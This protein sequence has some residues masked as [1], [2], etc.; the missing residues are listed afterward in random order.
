MLNSD[1]LRCKDEDQVVDLV[2]DYV[3]KMMGSDTTELISKLLPAI[4]D[5]YVSTQKLI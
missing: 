5:E 4:R 1:D 2:K 3:E